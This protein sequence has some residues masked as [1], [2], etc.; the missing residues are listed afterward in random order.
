VHVRRAPWRDRSV[1][2]LSALEVH[3]VELHPDAD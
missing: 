1:R 2:R 3:G